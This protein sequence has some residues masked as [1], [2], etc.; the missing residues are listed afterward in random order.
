MHILITADPEICVPPRLYGGIERIIDGLVGYY[1]EQGHTV[2]LIARS[3][4]TCEADN[5]VAWP[6][7]KSGGVLALA[8][9]AGCMSGA[10]TAFKPDIL[11]SFSRLA[12]LL[13]TLIGKSLPV[14][15]SYQ[16]EPTGRTVKMASKI[17]G[18]ALSFTGCSDYICQQGR[19]I[20]GEWRAIHNFV[21]CS[22]FAFQAEVKADA[23][24][25]YL[26]RI[27]Q[28]KGTYEAILMA[29]KA[30]VPLII[31]GNHAQEGEAGE[32]WAEKIEPHLK[33][34]QV[35]YIGPVNDQEKIDLLGKARAMLVP[36]QW[37]E[38]FGIVFAESLACGTPV[39]ASPRGALPE[40]VET[41]THGFLVSSIDEGAEAIAKLEQID[42]AA[43][44]QQAEVKFNRDVIGDQYLKLYGE[45]LAAFTS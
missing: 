35:D 22:R 4:S 26:S 7:G 28:I 24:L 17:G 45:K 6:V 38:P 33:P 9:N 43:C 14:I 34:G 10:I 20:A 41:G 19:R 36:I 15:M 3:G 23:P 32:Y 2:S 21:D 5:R 12:Y 16:R 30:G 1:R 8:K 25:V 44:R 40:I 37:N 31:A 39:I 29:E 27:E 13:H 42:R 18:D 11:H